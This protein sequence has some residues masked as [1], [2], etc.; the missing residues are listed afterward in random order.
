MLNRDNLEKQI[1]NALEQYLPTTF[2]TAMKA[3]LPNESDAGNDMC[4]EFG[5]HI[6]DMLSEPLASSL[7][8]AIDYYVKNITITGT[9]LTTGSP[10]SQQAVL[11]PAPTPIVAGTIPNTLKIQ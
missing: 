4:K 11:I 3:F 8:S 1:K 5:Q 2:E 7:A 9:I 6:S 10:V